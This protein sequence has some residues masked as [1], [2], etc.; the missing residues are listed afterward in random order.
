M[1]PLLTTQFVILLIVSLVNPPR[2]IEET[3]TSE[4][5]ITQH[6]V[7]GHNTDALFFIEV[8]FEA[9]LIVV[10]C[11]L[12][13]QT[14]HPWTSALVRANNSSLPCATLLLSV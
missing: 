6:V 10:G 9:G 13:F 8:V 7:C 12:A 14:R 1:L 3:E 2:Q 11:V 5:V 4:G